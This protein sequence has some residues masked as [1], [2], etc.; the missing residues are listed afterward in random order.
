MQ[1]RIWNSWI[2][3]KIWMNTP[4]SSFPEIHMGHFSVFSTNP[5][6]KTWYKLYIQWFNTLKTGIP[7]EEGD[8]ILKL[9]RRVSRP[10]MEFTF[11][12]RSKL[13]TFSLRKLSTSSFILNFSEWADRTDLF[14]P[15]HN[16]RNHKKMS[17]YF[18]E[19]M[20]MLSEWWKEKLS[21]CAI[22]TYCEYNENIG[23][24][25]W[26]IIIHFSH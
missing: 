8:S 9:L 23:F 16:P 7:V 22:T 26:D 15:I 11:Q 17:D 5:I 4:S 1:I 14:W 21:I 19:K 25:I 20:W 10:E 3:S 2:V 24:S 6:R 13:L 18:L 12:V